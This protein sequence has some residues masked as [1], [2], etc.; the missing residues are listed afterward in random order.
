MATLLA[1]TQWDVDSDGS[2]APQPIF[3]ALYDTQVASPYYRDGRN[4][5]VIG[6]VN[7]A[8]PVTDLVPGATVPVPG[9]AAQ[10]T[11][12]ITGVIPTGTSVSYGFDGPGI[13]TFGGSLP[14]NGPLITAAEWGKQVASG[15]NGKH[16]DVIFA[17]ASVVSELEVDILI[18]SQDASSFTVTN[19]TLV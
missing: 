16:G 17:Q 19:W 14:Q 15:L 2:P 7:T 12:K 6:Y 3:S 11:A 18:S 13:G 5:P 1:E 9:P 8:V 4:V 10:C